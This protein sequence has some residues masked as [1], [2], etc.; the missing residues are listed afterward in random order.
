[1]LK[2]TRRFPLFLF[3]VIFALGATAVAG[4][5]SR[6]L[7]TPPPPSV[8]LQSVDPQTLL[9]EGITLHAPNSAA[10]L[11]QSRA[12]AIAVE[13]NP[14][15]SARESVLVDFEDSHAVPAIHCLCWVVSLNRPD[16]EIVLPSLGSDAKTSFAEK[17]FIVMID[18]TT[19]K[20]VEGTSS[21]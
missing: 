11:S 7:A 18:A 15:A 1:M 10:A 20:F 4:I 2:L 12:E 21:S 17:F 19:G 5:T 6:V 3:L 16:G 13:M 14:G 9:D 8:A